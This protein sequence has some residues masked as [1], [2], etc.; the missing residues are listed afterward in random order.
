MNLPYVI[1][2]DTVV[3]QTNAC[4]MYLGRLTGLAG[5]TWAE[6]SAVEQALCQL[7][8]LRNDTVRMA[9]NPEAVKGDCKGA[10]HLAGSVPTNFKKL[11]GFIEQRGTKYCAADTV[12]V[13]DFHLWEMIDQAER[14]AR[15]LGKPSPLEGFTRLASIYES[16]RAD[17]KL[18]AYFASSMYALPQNNKMAGYGGDTNDGR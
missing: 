10:A 13:A 5:R 9:Y 4:L 12:T 7:M 6:V 1:D 2:G 11:E 3:T 15:F 8:D 16:L 18:A 14:L 17:P